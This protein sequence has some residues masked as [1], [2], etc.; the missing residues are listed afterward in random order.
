VVP[1]KFGIDWRGARYG[2]Q[3]VVYW[4][5][6]TVAITHGGIEIGQGVNTKV[7]AH[8]PTGGQSVYMGNN[9]HTVVFWLLILSNV[10]WILIV[11]LITKLLVHLMWLVFYAGGPGLRI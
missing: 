5:D 8:T 4:P 11:D 7:R 6:G 3:V 2:S 1:L 10:K 9:P